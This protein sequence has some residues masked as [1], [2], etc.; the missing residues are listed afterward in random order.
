MTD[1]FERRNQ[2]VIDALPQDRLLV[3]SPRQGWQP[4]CAFPGVP[5]PTDPFPAHSRDELSQRSRDHSGLPADPEMAEKVDRD[6]SE[7]LKWKAFRRR[8]AS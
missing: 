3:Y 2:H 6:Y 1:W 8:G 4:L 7:T 5:V